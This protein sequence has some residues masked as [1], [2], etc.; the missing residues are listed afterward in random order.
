MKYNQTIT[1]KE[2]T[3]TKDDGGSIEETWSNVS[4]LVDVP[5][6]VDDVSSTERVISER[7]GYYISK[8]V[9]MD[10]NSSVSKNQRVVFD[11][12][13]YTITYVRNPNNLN[14]KLEI[15]IYEV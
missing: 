4:G 3:E 12:V 13:E 14:R 9:F 7:N 11:S 8:R 6:L 5:C 10:Y 2:L 15:D 1:F